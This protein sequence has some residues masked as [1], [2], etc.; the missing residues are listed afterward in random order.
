MRTVNVLSILPLGEAE[1]Q[2]IEAVDPAVRLID[3][4]GWFDDEIRE[5]W[6]DFAA[7]RY[8][9]AGSRAR[10]TRPERDALLAEAEVILGGWP[11]PL[12][13]KS[14]APRLKWFH[15]RP[16]GASNLRLGDLWESDVLV[17]TSRGLGNA[18]PIAEYALAGMLHFAKG[19]NRAAAD[20][21]AGAFDHRAYRPLLI[22]GKTACIV[23]VGGIG[24]EVGRLSAALGMRV[25][26]TR[27]HPP[28]A[29][30]G[31][32]PGFAEI[33]GPDELNRLLRTSDFIVVCAQW[34]PETTGLIGRAALAAMKPGAVLVNIARGEI[35]DEA[36]L[37]EALDDGRLGGAA[38]DVY[39]GEFEHLPD[40]RLWRHPN[41]LITPHTSGGTDEDRH[42]AV[43]LFCENLR[44]YLD[45]RRLRNVVD[46]ARGY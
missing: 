23:G 8:L 39:A 30:E 35:V 45:G 6:P 16:A 31:L 14:R 15:Q 10:G 24:A 42:Q 9:P 33:G 17:S 43:D 20:R 36:A 32:P 28:E 12:D 4:A 3:A 5:T 21:A 38:L 46:W 1:R 37:L 7:R 41:V 2:K 34:T 29:G 19:L 26:G 40:E 44:A 22:E 25:V 27:R 11:F 13:L 18:L